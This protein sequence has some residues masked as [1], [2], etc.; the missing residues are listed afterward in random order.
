LEL[1]EEQDDR[2]KSQV[3]DRDT[4][5]LAVEASSGREWYRWADD[6]LSI[7]SFGASAPADR[8]FEKFGF[9]IGGIKSRACKLMGVENRRVTINGYE[10]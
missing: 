10:F 8:L 7:N 5:V 1:F 9:T 3:I 2:Y 6:V 4:K